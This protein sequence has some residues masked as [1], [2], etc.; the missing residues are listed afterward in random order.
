LIAR[1]RTG[2]VEAYSTLFERHREAATRLA[3]QLARAPSDADDLVAEAFER[4]LRQLR[5]GK[6][7]DVSFRAY[8]LTTLRHAHFR[9]HRAE[10]VVVPTDDAAILDQTMD[11]PD[12]V[13]SAFDNAAAARAFASLPERWQMILWHVE[14]EAQRP[15][16]VAELLGM[17]PNA[18]SALA[19]RA[20]EA[21]R[22]AYLL[23]HVADA[24]DESHVAVLE[25]LPA[26][27]RKKLG[28]RDEQKVR[29]HLAGCVTCSAA[30]AEV[31]EMGSRLSVLLGPVIL[32]AASGPYLRDVPASTLTLAHHPWE[33]FQHWI[34]HAS[35]PTGA[36]H[37][38]VVALTLSLAIGTLAGGMWVA[39]PDT[40]TGSPL[41]PD[42]SASAGP[43]D[44]GDG[45]GAAASTPPSPRTTRPAPSTPP[46]TSTIPTARS[47]TSPNATTTS[48]EFG[49]EGPTPRTP[50]HSDVVL[51]H[52][53]TTA[54][55]GNEPS[56]TESPA[57]PIKA[58]FEVVPSEL[59][60]SVRAWAS[61]G[62]G[63]FTYTWRYAAGSTATGAAARHRYGLHG[64]YTIV[65]TVTDA[66]GSKTVTRS[67]SVHAPNQPPR[68]E[69]SVE[70]GR[71]S[72]SVDA[73]A[74]SDPDGRVVAF[75]WDFGDG[76]F[77]TGIVAWHRYREA[78]DYL[79]RLTVT[80][81]RGARASRV[82]TISVDCRWC[83]CP[84]PARHWR[85]VDRC[86]G[87][88]AWRAHATD[89]GSRSRPGGWRSRRA[90]AGP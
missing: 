22:Q 40:L 37:K 10:K 15:A 30:Y 47:T 78:G 14:V 54:P 12:R 21:L 58:G 61:G 34:N 72:I 85:H 90:G 32:G 79:V 16:Q 53:G 19:Y 73:S 55:F 13:L 4:V 63:R 56:G 11:E 81:D 57:P 80:D 71:E 29:R 23:Q 18:V 36:T 48:P 5:Q 25:L 67:V 88:S 43:V 68:A 35:A 83:G 31:S 82:R 50:P 49:P 24:P 87:S 89:A 38:A 46:S 2:D 33:T 8:L 17:K 6:G 86:D 26:L 76:S 20:R 66:T 51:P 64:T 27:V 3:T 44:L 9:Q 39:R 77:G 1:A 42:R 65:L 52:P 7:P 45:A 28:R 62:S 84:R 75:A 59:S 60:V 74:S 41:P 69:F 70:L